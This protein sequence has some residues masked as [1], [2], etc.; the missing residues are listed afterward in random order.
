[1]VDEHIC[2]IQLHLSDFFSLKA[3]QHTVYKWARDLDV[4][5]EIQP[6]HLFATLSGEVLLEM[7]NLASGDW[8]GTGH[9]L[10][11]LYLTAGLY[12]DA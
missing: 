1:M 2:E 5:A 10:Q 4:T 12:R 11:H 9:A 3:G 8:N 7:V 6:G